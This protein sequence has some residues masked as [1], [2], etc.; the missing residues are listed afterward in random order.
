MELETRKQQKKINGTKSLFS[1]KINKID[2]SLVRQEKN[3]AEFPNIKT[4]IEA[5]T[6]QP[7]DIRETRQEYYKQFL[8]F[9]KLTTKK[10][11]A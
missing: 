6:I 7:E 2:K 5:I 10:K 4:K 9:I 11:Q 8:M 1:E 3:K